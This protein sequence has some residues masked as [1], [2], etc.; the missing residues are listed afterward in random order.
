MDAYG[1]G[2]CDS[3]LIGAA[4][5]QPDDA[6]LL[7][8]GY[9]GTLRA[10]SST[11]LE[12]RCSTN[13]DEIFIDDLPPIMEQMLGPWLAKALDQL[14]ERAAKNLL[15]F[16]AV[17][18]PLN[19]LL[20][21]L[22][23][24]LVGVLTQAVAAGGIEP[25]AQPPQWSASDILGTFP[26]LSPLLGGVVSE[27]V[28]A[29]VT[30]LKRLNRDQHWIAANL[31]LSKL[32]PIETVSGTTSDIHAG[33]HC[34]LRV[35][36][37]GGGCLYYKPRPVTGEWLWHGLLEAI[38]LLDPE[39]R[40]PAARVLGDGASLH[41]G[42]V[43][44]VLPGDELLAENFDE[45]AES[46]SAGT[47]GY[48]HAAGAMLCLAQNAR[49]T[50]LH[51]GNIVASPGG[52]AVTDAECFATPDVYLRRDLKVSLD[53]AAMSDAL[54]SLVST[55]LLPKRSAT[56][57]PDVSGLFGHA[58][59]VSGVKLPKW[60]VTKDGRYRLTAVEAEL[61]TH[62]NALVQTSAIAVL[63]QI[64]SGYR[65]AA[66]LLLRVRETLIGSGTR[67]LAV[68][69][70][71]HAPRIVVR[72]TLMYGMLLSQSLEPRYL[73]SRH[74]RRQGILTGLDTGSIVRQPWSLLRSEARDLLEM[75]VPRLVILPGT[76]TLA[77]S[78]GRRIARG[79]TAC[80]PAQ[81]VSRQI[82]GLSRE[83]VENVHVPALI[84]TVL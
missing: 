68:L 51:L 16:Q 23:E 10:A 70:K 38:A 39:L 84:S 1:S 21:V 43:S 12:M 46:N 31:R 71:V 57:Y 2:M 79:Y 28:T 7:V 14:N 24:R 37:L 47:L 5:H 55:G 61:V 20:Q 44:S 42:W 56:G 34:V 9:R 54:V 64:L 58:A 30:F 49:L 67:W 26:L 72:D 13:V 50:D 48:W 78:S 83:S 45:R 76:R 3:P 77:A 4:S 41:Y 36:F 75:H 40:L 11:T 29:T 65:H 81:A 82:E 80:T 32:P 53:H 17:P 18:V 25:G 35:C 63:P 73:H 52:P 59:P 62:R 66:D 8:V 6:R 19:S 69:E 15:I 33:G 27:W 74:R 60:V 22:K